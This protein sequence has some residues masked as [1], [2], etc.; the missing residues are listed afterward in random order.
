MARPIG[1]PTRF[2]E[3]GTGDELKGRWQEVPRLTLDALRVAWLASR[4]QVVAVL[5]LQTAAGGAMA[6]QLLAGQRVLQK[7]LAIGA[8]QVAGS[9]LLPAFAVLI[10]AMIAMGAFTAL[11]EERQRLLG[12]LV[13]QY[14][15]AQIIGVAT[16]VE[17]AAFENPDF[18]DQLERARSSAVTRSVQMVSS[19][20]GVTLNLLTSGGI[21]V[22]LLVLEPLLLPL[23]LVSAVPMLLSTVFNSRRAYN[24][25]WAM[26]PENRERAYL[27]ELL[28]KREAAKEIRVFEATPFLRSRYEVLTAERLRRMREFLRERRGVALMGAVASTIGMGVALAALAALIASGRIGV[29][30]AM[31]AGAAMQ[32]L[33]TR[34][35]GMMAGLGQLVESG[36]FV[37]DYNSF[38]RLL[39]EA[40]AA[41]EAKAAPAPGVVD[42][43][44]GR[45]ATRFNGVSV[46][47][48]SFRYPAT[49]APVLDDVSL[50]IDPGEVV[51]LVGEN[52]SGKTTLVKLI[53]QLYE[54]LSGRI[55]WRGPHGE[56]VDPQAVRNDMTV[57]FQDFLHYYLTA[58]ENIAVGRVGR[59]PTMEAVRGAARRAGAHDFLSRL[60]D[61]YETRLGRQFADGYDLSIGQWQRLALARAFFRGGSFLVL[62]EPTASLDPR[63][64][65]ELF[66]QMRKLWSGRSVLLISHRF[67]SVRAADRIYVLRDGRV[68]EGGDHVE[69]M[70]AGGHYA[71]LFSLQAAAYLDQSTNVQVD[72]GR[73]K[74]PAVGVR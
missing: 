74:A 67:S 50:R 62:D 33:S 47:G 49:E 42:A 53:C 55:A 36:M 25:E 24:F 28:T 11:A 18:H 44:R 71:E 6:M 26:T 31:A 68:V 19:I 20:G 12:E 10:V 72:V 54:P 70:A 35:F 30:T 22:A 57:V 9:A 63:A 17:M 58:A 3:L 34:L 5:L 40:G 2:V 14:A 23:V 46:E 59:E 41:E 43:R 52:G 27:V 69:L 7:L 51:A 21:G 8:G 45:R 60:P 1:E 38:L 64:E 56:D 4:R 13:A 48:V 16:R 37:D 29:A 32:Q 61:G 73:K 15:F 65:S 39:P 66:Q